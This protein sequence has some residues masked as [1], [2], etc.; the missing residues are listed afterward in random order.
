MAV[1][2]DALVSQY[3]AQ[4]ERMQNVL[5][6]RDRRW[7]DLLGVWREELRHISDHAS[8]KTHVARTAR[9][10][11]GGMDSLGEGVF[12]REDPTE[13]LTLEELSAICDMIRFP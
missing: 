6:G 13:R 4:L 2:D 1:I 3:G 11:A 12:M 5:R 9:N 10:I 8:L 7:F